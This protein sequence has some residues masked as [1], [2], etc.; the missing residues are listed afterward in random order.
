MKVLNISIKEDKDK[1]AN[2]I[3]K[4]KEELKEKDAI[5]KSL[6]SK[7]AQSDVPSFNF[8]G[9]THAVTLVKKKNY[10]KIS[11][12]SSNHIKCD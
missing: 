10:L 6:Q 9:K 1:S 12:K 7:P 4:H 2:L 11:P 8:G 3:L 5:I